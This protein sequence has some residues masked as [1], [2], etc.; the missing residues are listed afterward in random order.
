MATTLTF[1]AGLVP[2]LEGPTDDQ[3]EM[4]DV[5]AMAIVD[6]DQ[7]N[8]VP[9]TSDNVTGTTLK[10]DVTVRQLINQENPF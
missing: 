7:K 10:I 3:E 1:S 2:E 9:G 6:I 5:S 8:H 4:V